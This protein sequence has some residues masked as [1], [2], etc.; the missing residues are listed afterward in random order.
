MQTYYEHLPT[1]E[2]AK[3]ASKRTTQNQKVLMVFTGTQTCCVMIFALL[4]LNGTTPSST[5]QALMLTLIIV[6]ATSGVLG[7]V[8]TWFT[9]KPPHLEKEDI[10]KRR[11]YAKNALNWFFI[12]QLWA[13]SVAVTQLV[14]STQEDSDEA[15]LCSEGSLGYEQCASL[16]TGWAAFFSTAS[17]FVAFTVVYLSVFF[18]DALLESLQDEVERDDTLLITKFVWLM[19]KKTTVGIHRFEDLIHKEFQELVEMGYLKLKPSK[20][21]SPNS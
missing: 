10:Q 14:Y 17:E 2:L 16:A 15:T 19:N 1:E 20:P 11:T 18:A 6:V 5:G 13:T 8:A 3:A 4:N 21:T 12:S 7:F 9:R